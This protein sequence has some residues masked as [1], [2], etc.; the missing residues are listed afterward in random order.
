MEKQGHF[1]SGPLRGY[2]SDAWE[3]GHRVPFIVRWPGVVKAGQRCDQLV[4]Q[5]DLMATLADILGVKLPDDAGEDSFS[6][7][8]LLQGG[9]Q[10]VR[11]HAV[12]SSSKRPAG[13]PQGAVEADLRARLRRLEH[14]R[15]DQPVQL[16]NLADDLGETKN[17]SAEKP[18]IVAELTALM[19]KTVADGRST[20]GASQKNDVPVRWKRFLSP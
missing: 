20:P 16:Y 12:N 9:D 17:L 5:A 15:D 1:P 4:H 13:D 14:G 3:G 11:E 6:L 10:P 19:E 2:K 8:P 18:E 7:L